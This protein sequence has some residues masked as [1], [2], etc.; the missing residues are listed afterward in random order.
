MSIKIVAPQIKGGSTRLHK[1]PFGLHDN[2][3]KCWLNNPNPKSTSPA[4]IRTSLSDLICS[5]SKFT[6]LLGC[7]MYYLNRSPN[8]SLLRPRWCSE[9]QF[10]KKH[11]L[12]PRWSFTGDIL[13]CFSTDGHTHKRCVK[14]ACVGHIGKAANPF[15]PRQTPCNSPYILWR[16]KYSHEISMQNIPQN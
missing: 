15:T 9:T 12:Q 11:L 1:I 4:G 7:F 3:N 8:S 13:S 16:I 14:G 5:F 10:N 2:L 6:L